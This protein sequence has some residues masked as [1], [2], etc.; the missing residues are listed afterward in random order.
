M[1]F[2]GCLRRDQLSGKKGKG[3]WV[4]GTGE[5]GKRERC[6]VKR[7]R[8]RI[9]AN[10][11]SAQG[12]ESPAKTIASSLNI[13]NSLLWLLLPLPSGWLLSPRPNCVGEFK[14][15]GE[16]KHSSSGKFSPFFLFTYCPPTDHN[17]YRYVCSC[18][19][20]RNNVSIQLPGLV[21]LYNN[22]LSLFQRHLL[23]CVLQLA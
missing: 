20:F 7:L 2:W 16:V 6:A 19:R 12:I 4:R 3:R 8:G 13:Q 9:G 15:V 5:G 10:S 22:I 23:N 18:R 17:Y 14:Q 11:P 21:T 1:F